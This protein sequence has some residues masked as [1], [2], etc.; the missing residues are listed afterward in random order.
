MNSADVYLNLN[1]LDKAKEYLQLA[2][3][4]FKK[5]AIKIGIY[6]GNTIKIGILLKEKKYAEIKEI[7]DNEHADEDSMEFMM[8]K[9]RN[10]SQHQARGN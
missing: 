4:V 8:Q 7:L 10:C 2:E 1:N 6:Y 3:P 9:I 5:Q